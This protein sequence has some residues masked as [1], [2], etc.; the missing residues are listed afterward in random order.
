M[1]YTFLKTFSLHFVF[2]R[3]YSNQFIIAFR[4]FKFFL[5][6]YV[7]ILCRFQKQQ[8]ALSTSLNYTDVT[9]VHLEIYTVQHVPV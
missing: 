1:E 8:F 2:K 4:K 3:F 9:A 7:V 5:H 6:M